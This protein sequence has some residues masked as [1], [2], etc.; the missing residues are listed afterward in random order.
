MSRLRVKP[1]ITGW[2]QVH[3]WRGPTDTLE[4]I[5]QRCSYDMYYIQHLSVWLD[6]QILLR[7]AVKG[8]VHKN[9]Y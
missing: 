6:L 8:F 1:G 4:Q 2:A 7:S 5:R 9:A 3:G